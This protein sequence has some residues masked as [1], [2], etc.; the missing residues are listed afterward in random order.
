MM[1]TTRRMV[2][3]TALTWLALGGGARG[4][5]LTYNV[6]DY[7][8]ITAPYTVSGTITTNGDLGASLPTSDIIAW[9][10]TV[11]N[12]ST[13]LFD[14]TQNNSAVV[15]APF[16]ATE[17]ELK[18]GTVNSAIE[19]KDN[20]G[21][22]ILWAD[23]GSANSI[24]RGETPT[25]TLWLGSLPSDGSSPVATISTVPEPSSVVLAGIGIGGVIACVLVRKRREQRREAVA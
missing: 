20:T 24:Y 7:A 1:N 13:V 14:L 4:G 12:G 8:T 25:S 16:G 19:L 15:L 6:V 21:D 17:T 22:E 9:D 10:I 23:A 3:L 5:D 11:T 2:A 18:V